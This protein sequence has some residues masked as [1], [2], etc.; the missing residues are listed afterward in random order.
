[1]EDIKKNNHAKNFDFHT[2]GNIYFI[3]GGI[4]SVF[5]KKNKKLAVTVK[6]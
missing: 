3:V 1:M 2:R 5:F 4:K 6:L